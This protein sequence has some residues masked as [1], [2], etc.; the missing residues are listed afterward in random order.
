V[1][2][3][4]ERDAEFVRLVRDYGCGADVGPL[5]R[6]KRL[7][8]GI[9]PTAERSSGLLWRKTFQM[10]EPN[11]RLALFSFSQFDLMEVIM[12]RQ[13]VVQTVPLIERLEQE[14]QRIR[15]EAKK[16]RP[17][18]ERHEMLRKARQ[19]DIA[20]SI[21]QWISSPGLKPPE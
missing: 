18:K 21:T 10:K 11:F 20:A 2:A 1:V 5:L 4:A 19:A 15:E 17:G 9:P 16:L 13:R 7:R 3:G 8:P 6:S 12:H 14:S